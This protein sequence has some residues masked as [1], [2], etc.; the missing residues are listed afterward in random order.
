MVKRLLNLVAHPV[1]GYHVGVDILKTMLRK[2]KRLINRYLVRFRAALNECKHSI[3]LLREP[4]HFTLTYVACGSPIISTL[5]RRIF[6]D[7]V[8]IWHWREERKRIN[9]GDYIAEVLVKKFGYKTVNYCN[10]SLLNILSIY[11]F[12]LLIIGSEL[13]KEKVDSL[14]VPE[15]YVWGQGK[16]HG[17]FFD[18]RSEPYAKK[19]KIFAVRGPRTIRQLKLDE[20]TPL[21]DP[22]LLMPVFFRIRRNPS[23][24]RITYI[25]HWTNR[26]GWDMKRGK[27][28]A[29]RFVDI[30][31][32]RRRFLSKLREI[33]SSKFVLTNS[34][35][36]AVISHAY[37]TPWALCLADGDQLNFPD[38]W[39]DFFEF[40]GIKN[41]PVAV[42]NYAEGLQWWDD[43]G[44]KAKTIDLLP[45][46]D[47]F[48]LPI[49][50]KRTL[51]IIRKMKAKQSVVEE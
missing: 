18:I 23:Q 44:S 35:H 15:I 16:G 36:T 34:F 28:G 37:G 9:F 2:A 4:D 27:L 41:R 29:E 19:V 17:E 13:H 5:L 31:C 3:D 42:R 1:L 11:D 33:V 51:T 20:G 38:K 50:S 47:S 43:V 8:L 25:P 26:G 12:C 7:R 32:T 40:L 30:M 45:L 6:T 48:P 14:K 24:Y 21:G 46:L 49:R 10:A 22:A 39:R